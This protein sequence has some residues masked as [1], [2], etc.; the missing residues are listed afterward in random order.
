LFCNF[1]LLKFLSELFKKCFPP[2]F[3]SSKILF[4]NFI[5]FRILTFLFPMFSAIMFFY[6]N[7]LFIMLTSN[8]FCFRITLNF[9]LFKIFIQTFITNF[10]SK[11]FQYNCCYVHFLSTFVLKLYFHFVVQKKSQNFFELFFIIYK[12]H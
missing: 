1:F 7:L 4:P 6:F 10:V 8:F 11:I 5:P 2:I 12:L 9:F 3:F